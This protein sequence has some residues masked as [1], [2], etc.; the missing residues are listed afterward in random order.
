MNLAELLRKI[1]WLVRRKKYDDDLAEEMA[2]HREQAARALQEDGWSATE[3]RYAAARQFGNAVRL[4][5]ESIATVGFRWETAW[6]DLRYALR[7]LRNNPGFACTAILI[8]G[9]GIGAT[10]AIFSAVNPILFASLP[11]PDARHLLSVYE[12]GNR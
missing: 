1:G 7:Q 8:L 2:F 3:A 4:K 12:S 5:E 11:Y 9:L 6:Q 10:T